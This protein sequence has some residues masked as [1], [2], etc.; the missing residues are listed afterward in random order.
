M[1]LRLLYT[2][3]SFLFL[4]TSC[5]NSAERQPDLKSFDLERLVDSQVIFL[6]ENEYQVIKKS[7]LGTS[8]DL[9]QYVPDSAG[10]VREMGIIRTADISK[11]GLRSYYTLESYD[12]LEYTIEHYSLL[13]SGN[14]NIIYQKIY[15]DAAS[16]QLLKIQALQNVNNPIYDSNRYLEITFKEAEK[17]QE[18]I[19]SILVRGYQTMI[20][21]DTVIYQSISKIIPGK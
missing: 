21:S 18:V 2:G 4:L 9:V 15:R 11:P 3:L 6:A 5:G 8:D 1:D 20:L 14:S 10:W 12:S 7:S 19:D 13:N 16:D 17:D